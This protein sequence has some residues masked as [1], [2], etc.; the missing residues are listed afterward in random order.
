M[1]EFGIQGVPDLTNALIMTSFLSAGNIGVFSAA[2]VLHGMA[3]DGK[4]PSFFGKCHKL[5]LP[6]Y[7]VT[8]ALAFCL[9]SLRFVGDSA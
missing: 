2:R 5:G 9:L 8:V 6:Y 7:S 4:A 1:V 3:I